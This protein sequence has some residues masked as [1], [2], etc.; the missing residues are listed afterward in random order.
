MQ[1]ILITGAS[2]GIGAAL[3]AHYAR[4]GAANIFICGRDE[5]R[6]AEVAETAR[7]A[8]ATTIHTRILDVTNA[9][10]TRAWIEEC[11]AVAPLDLVIANAG[12]G[13]PDER[14]P[15]TRETIDVN[16]L[17]VVNTVFPA[18]DLGVAQ[19]AMLSSIAGYRGLPDC[20]V[21]SASKAFVKTWGAGLR[22]M[23]VPRG[24]KVNV[25]C[26]G[27]VRSRITD[28]NTVKMPFFMEAEK[29]AHIIARGLAK[30]KGLIVFPWQ[31]RFAGWLMA[32]IPESLAEKIFRVRHKS[33]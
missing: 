18:L 23:L 5:T 21:Y 24:I 11:H 20:P 33:G 13:I 6:L 26:P 9:V 32:I 31:M 19:I 22:G 25:I 29:A 12:I 2:S 16:V 27:Y 28:K 30:D 8:A 15:A 7:S 4:A 14:E 17:G 10:A 3:A 1:N